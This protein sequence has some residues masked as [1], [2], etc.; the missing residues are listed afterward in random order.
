MYFRKAA[1]SPEPKPD[2]RKHFIIF[3]TALS[4]CLSALAQSEQ[5]DTLDID[6]LVRNDP[7]EDTSEAVLT[8]DT[9]AVFRDFF[10]SKDSVQSWKRKKEYSWLRDIDS[11]LHEAAAAGSN[12]QTSSSRP[13]K[14]VLGRN[15]GGR[16][17]GGGSGSSRSPGS[18]RSS[19][20]GSISVPDLS[21]LKIFLW[22]IAG[23]LVIFIISR[24][25]L[26]KGF[27]KTESKKSIPVEDS[28][29]EEDIAGKDFESLKRKALA[30]NNYRMATRYMFLSLLRDLDDK[31]LIRYSVDKTNSIY[32]HELPG[33]YRNSFASVSLYYEY[34]WYG[35]APLTAPVY[36]RV[37]QAF[38]Q[39]V[40]TI[41]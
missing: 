7:G 6:G 1:S 33:H 2:M 24:L 4:C 31:K 38:D 25:F 39:F 23:G 32:L 12:E 26:N 11:L 35:N 13:G 29:E 30:E 27:F 3:I 20:G 16:G 22:I 21:F 34:I 9:A 37:E 18:S 40:K 41:R 36:E 15:G 17:G 8:G 14:L 28:S 5:T 10:L 19:S